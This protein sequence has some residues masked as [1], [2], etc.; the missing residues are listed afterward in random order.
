MS[1]YCSRMQKLEDFIQVDPK[2]LH[3]RQQLVG[4]LQAVNSDADYIGNFFVQQSFKTMTNRFKIHPS[5]LP[6]V[7]ILVLKEAVDK[8]GYWSCVLHLFYL[9]AMTNQGIST[10][11]I[12]CLVLFFNHQCS[13]TITF[14]SALLNIILQ[15]WKKNN[16]G[17]SLYKRLVIE[18]CNVRNIKFSAHLSDI[19]HG[20]YPRH[21]PSNQKIYSEEE[22]TTHVEKLNSILSKYRKLMLLTTS[23]TSDS[24]SYYQLFQNLHND[25][26]KTLPGFGALRSMHLIHLCSLIGLI[27]LEFYIFTPMHNKGGPGEYLY[28]YLNFKEELDHHEGSNIKDCLINWTCSEMRE[29]QKHFTEQYTPNMNENVACIIGRSIPKHDIFYFLP[30]YDNN[31]N[32]FTENNIQLMFRI[33]GYRSNQWTLEVNNGNDTTVKLHSQHMDQNGGSIIT[34]S[35]LLDGRLIDTNHPVN[36]NI[37]KEI[38]STSMKN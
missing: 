7:R 26:S 20:M 18:C 5:I 12:Y 33:N 36:M 31:T 32:K 22:V 6:N 11:D 10:S 24:K 30:R 37:M 35:R 4:I 17:M 16:C 8:M 14:T 25:I 38:F 1:H 9:Y 34:Y 28:N 27:Q 21:Q 15:R 19:G 23:N 2:K 29:L 13:G 3:G